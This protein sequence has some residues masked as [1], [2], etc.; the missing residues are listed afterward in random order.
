M[1]KVSVNSSDIYFNNIVTLLYY[2]NRE[3]EERVIIII[4]I[5]AQN[6]DIVCIGANVFVEVSSSVLSYFVAKSNPSNVATEYNYKLIIFYKF[7]VI[8]WL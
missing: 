3:G 4:I 5:Y 1:Q 8:T 7:Q 6:S 2:M